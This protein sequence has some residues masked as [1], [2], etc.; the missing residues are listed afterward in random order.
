M[1][2]LCGSADQRSV[3]AQSRS[4]RVD[5]LP[6]RHVEGSQSRQRNHGII[7]SD[8]RVCALGRL[9]ADVVPDVLA[10]CLCAVGRPHDVIQR[11]AST[12]PGVFLA[13]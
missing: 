5:Q 1:E 10:L 6:T 2:Q 11:D 12:S 4:G 9:A 8:P 3:Q 13:Q 7:A